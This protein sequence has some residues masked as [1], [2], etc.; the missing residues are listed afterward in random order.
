MHATEYLRSPGN[1]TLGPVVALVGS[2]RFLK[3]EALAE[4][5]SKVIGGSD[6]SLS[7]AH[8]GG[9][10]LEWHT[11][12][13]GLLTNSMWSPAQV[14]VID[15]ADAF[16]SDQRPHFEKYL[17]RPA[18]KSL[19]VLD[20]KSFPA[21]TNLAKKVAQIGLIL[22]CTPLPAPQM[23]GWATERAKSHYKKLFERGAAALLV[24]LIGCEF[25]SLDQELAK[26]AAFAGPLETITTQS[27]EKLVGGWKTETTWR[28]TDA[29][30]D[31]DYSRALELLD[32]LLVAGEPPIK[33]MGG[34]S[35][36]FKPVGRAQELIAQG[37]SPD[38]ALVAAGAKSFAAPQLARYISRVGRPRCERI[39]GWLLE[40]DM[41]LKG[42]GTAMS[43]RIV[44]ERLFFRL[45]AP[46]SA[47]R[48]PSRG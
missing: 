10:R 3:L 41:D 39:V 5:T 34:V 37:Q 29:I 38:E 47:S 32:K 44:L 4:I 45:S 46:R 33:L 28:M 23:I 13:D 48:S 43:E 8:Y 26:L 24:E 20:V 36:V 40:A 6:Q 9:D 16:I 15:E 21:T 30:R 35:F 17:E 27:V 14:V 42:F 7:V 19:L 25:G 2:E 12:A 11:V 31:G 22:E 18:K 1:R